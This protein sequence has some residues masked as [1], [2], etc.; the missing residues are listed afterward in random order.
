M[1]KRLTHLFIYI[2]SALLLSG[3]AFV[4]REPDPHEGMVE[5]F[6]GDTNIWIYPQSDVPVNTVRAE[7]F[8]IDPN[9]NRVYCGG[10]YSAVLRGIDVSGFQQEIDWA[11]VRGAGIDFAIIR[12]GGRAYGAEGE[13]YADGLFEGNLTGAKAEGI[14]TGVYFFSQAM[15][16]QEA[17]E[18]ADFV[19]ELLQGRRLDLPVFFDWE[20]VSGGRAL[21]LDGETM[22]Q[23][24]ETFCRTI[25]D[26][27]Y[28]AGVYFNLDTSYYGYNMARLTDYDFWC[29]AIGD[30]PFCYYAHDF[31]QYSFEGEVPG[32]STV[33]DLNMMFIK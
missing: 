11:Q 6:N 7:D 1:K 8:I 2:L 10:E 19:L 20:R 31:W 24:A 14:M 17:K 23:C 12:I 25:E 9:G 28:E 26:A 30:Y 4:H 22:T 32:I 18:E 33:C 15:T 27:G 5:V 21:E 3:C 16:V 13:L 29:A